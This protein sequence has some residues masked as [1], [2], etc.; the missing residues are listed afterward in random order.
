MLVVCKRSAVASLYVQVIPMSPPPPLCYVLLYFP[1]AWALCVL[2]R[3]KHLVGAAC[4][5]YWER[6]F[7]FAKHILTCRPRLVIGM[8]K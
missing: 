5:A 6:G 4:R 8:G 7:L 2:P 1:S 3:P